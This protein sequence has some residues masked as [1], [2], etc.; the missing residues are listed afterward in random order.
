MNSSFRLQFRATR[1]PFLG[2]CI[3]LFCAAITED[4]G[5]RKVRIARSPAL[6]T[7][8]DDELC[9]SQSPM[10]SLTQQ[11]A[12]QLMDELWQTGLRP[13]EGTGSAGALAAT[14]RHLSDMRALVFKQNPK[15]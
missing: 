4:N 14:E 13:T 10:L 11:S 12:Q 6:D 15:L 5:V 3:E 2:D 8:T 1:S 7:L 9:C